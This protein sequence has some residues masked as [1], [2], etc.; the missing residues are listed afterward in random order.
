M[1]RMHGAVVLTACIVQDNYVAYMLDDIARQYG[2]A[3]SP[4]GAGPT[5]TVLPANTYVPAPAPA[6]AT[7]PS[8]PEDFQEQLSGM[9]EAHNATLRRSMMVR[10]C[11][12][13]CTLLI[14][15]QFIHPS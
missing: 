12:H 2:T 8:N 3:P 6:P 13:P 1:S 5:E 4:P 10:R 14:R 11:L 9:L 7:A 15:S